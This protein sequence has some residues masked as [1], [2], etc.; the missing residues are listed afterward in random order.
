M[1]SG[2]RRMVLATPWLPSARCTTVMYALGSAAPGLRAVTAGSFHR[3]I[4][5]RK[6]L[7]RTGPVSFSE[8]LRVMT[9]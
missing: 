3:V 6:I 9:L 2:M 8:P 4:W 7:A 1:E 5:P